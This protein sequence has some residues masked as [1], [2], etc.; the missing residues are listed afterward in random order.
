MFEVKNNSGRLTENQKASGVFSMDK[1]AN[2]DGCGIDLSKGTTRTYEINT[3]RKGEIGSK[4]ATG[5]ATFY[6]LHYYD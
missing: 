6:V 4:G 3:S 1:T 2:I 5:T